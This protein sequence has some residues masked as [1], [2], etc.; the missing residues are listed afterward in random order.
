[1]LEHAKMGICPI[2]HTLAFCVQVIAKPLPRVQ[3][4]DDEQRHIARDLQD[5]TRQDL[6]SLLM[7][8]GRAEQRGAQLPPELVEMLSE[9][10]LLAQK[11]SGDIRTFMPSSPALAR[12]VR[13]RS[14]D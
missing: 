2:A 13:A 6:A 3:S 12:R 7:T 8:L 11:I 14:G 4:Q 9:S 10:L 1:M 5:A